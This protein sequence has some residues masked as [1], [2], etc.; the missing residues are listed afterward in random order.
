MPASRAFL[1]RDHHRRLLTAHFA[2][3]LVVLVGLFAVN[4]FVTPDRFWAHWV[5]LA[6]LPLLAL[7]LAIF[8]RSTLATM[9]ASREPKDR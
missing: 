4:R 7:H 3:M 6:W 5:A 2:V 8:A 9:G 1:R